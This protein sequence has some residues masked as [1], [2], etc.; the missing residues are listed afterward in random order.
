VIAIPIANVCRIPGRSASENHRSLT[1]GI[2]TRLAI[3]QASFHTFDRAEWILATGYKRALAIGYQHTP[4]AHPRNR[5]RSDPIPMSRAVL[6]RP[7]V[8]A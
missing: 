7:D 2:P 1:G 5:D 3:E 8:A 6:I 4:F